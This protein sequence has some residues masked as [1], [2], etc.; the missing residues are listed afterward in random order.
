MRWIYAGPAARE[1]LARTVTPEGM[2]ARLAETRALLLAPGA[3]GFEDWLARDPLRLAMVP[4][5]SRRELAAG[6]V[7]GPG[8]SFEADQGRAQ[9]IVVQPR[10]SAFDS[11]AAARF[12]DDFEDASRAVRASHPGAT[13]EVTGGHAIAHATEAMFKRDLCLSSALSLVFAS[14][15]FVVTFRRA[16]ALVAV[17]PPL[18]VGTLWTTGL[19]AFFP[20]GL[21]GVAVAFMAVVVGVGVDTGVHVYAALLEGRRRGLDPAEAARFARRSTWR[22]T[23]LAATAAGLAF[24]SLA[25]SGLVALQQLGLLCGVGEFLTSVAILW[26]TPEIGALLER[27]APPAARDFAWTPRLVALT[28]TRRRALGVIVTAIGVVVVVALGAWPKTGDAVVAIRPRGLAP[29]ATQE[30]IYGLFGGRP[31]QW[32]VIAE[33]DTEERAEGR[34]DA[35]AEA[36]EPLARDGTI[37]GMDALGGYAP[38]SS[39]GAARLRERDRLESSR[40]P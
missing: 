32:V 17:L 30:T 37:D 2:R 14:L 26:M 31:G 38:A 1:A 33:D 6:V 4:W 10:G 39:T 16:R 23:L 9:L 8:G 18:V 29:L 25:I 3:I 35:V 40:A 27:R 11:E 21:A 19:A 13:L 5:E 12:V 7:A 20:H 24:A 34:A 22:P 36:L 28:G 15:M